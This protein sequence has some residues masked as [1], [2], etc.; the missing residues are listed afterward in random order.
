MLLARWTARANE[1]DPSHDSSTTDTSR[2]RPPLPIRLGRG[3]LADRRDIRIGFERRAAVVGRRGV[4]TRRAQVIQEVIHRV[5]GHA[6]LLAEAVLVVV[7]RRLEF[8][9]D[10]P[11]QP[12]GSRGGGKL[13]RERLAGRFGEVGVGDRA[14]P[15][16]PRGEN[17]VAPAGPTGARRRRG[18]PAA[19]VLAGQTVLTVVDE[20]EIL[21]QRVGGGGTVLTLEICP[22]SGG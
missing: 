10:R 14:E 18:V 21:K 19:F 5:G 2:M 17:A 8:G 15:D 13:G 12:I 7:R 1:G 4:V 9:G 16:R 6:P 20:S 11:Q 3:R 22:G